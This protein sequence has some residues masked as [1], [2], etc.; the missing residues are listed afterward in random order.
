MIS[1]LGKNLNN[2]SSPRIA[3]SKPFEATLLSN[4]GFAS[5]LKKDSNRKLSE[6]NLNLHL[7]EEPKVSNSNN[8]NNKFQMN[9]KMLLSSPLSEWI[10]IGKNL[11][12]DPS[13][14]QCKE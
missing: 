7:P 2:E 12:R 10:N 4:G 8:Y 3:V 13:Y 6:R 14:E 5:Q 11:S 1:F 9:A